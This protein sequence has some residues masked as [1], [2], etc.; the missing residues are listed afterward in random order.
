MVLKCISNIY[1]NLSKH[2]KKYWGPWNIYCVILLNILRWIQTYGG[3]YML[4]IK[5]KCTCITCVVMSKKYVMTSERNV[6]SKSMPWLLKSMSWC[7]K[8]CNYAKSVPLRPKVLKVCHDIKS[9]LWC[10]KYVAISGSMSCHQ[11]LDNYVVMLTRGRS[12]W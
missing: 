10:L 6:T 7:Q 8:A 1:H 9:T 12:A 11:T 5:S 4:V 3:V 2:T